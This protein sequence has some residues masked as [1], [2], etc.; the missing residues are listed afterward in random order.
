MKQLKETYVST[1]L[2]LVRR[3]W[4]KQDDQDLS[5]AD[6]YSHRLLIFLRPDLDLDAKK[7]LKDSS[8]TQKYQCETIHTWFLASSISEEGEENSQNHTVILNE[9]H[10]CLGEVNERQRR[11]YL[12]YCFPLGTHKW[13]EI[14]HALWHCCFTKQT[15]PIWCCKQ[16]KTNRIYCKHF[17]NY[18]WS[19]LKSFQ[20]RKF[21]ADFSVFAEKI[22]FL[23][24]TVSIKWSLVTLLY[25]L[26]TAW[27]TWPILWLCAYCNCPVYPQDMI[28]GAL[29]DLCPELVEITTTWLWRSFS[30]SVSLA[31][32]APHSTP[33]PVSYERL[34]Y[35]QI[36]RL[37]RGDMSHC[38]ELQ[39]SNKGWA[40][41]QKEVILALLIRWWKV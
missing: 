35:R 20:H 38:R 33:L 5:L 22:C 6:D 4:G 39:Y 34:L 14:V 37:W 24:N 3:V 32:N 8:V 18:V 41:W 27:S 26:S 7:T 2:F 10:L 15:L 21:T 9:S 23:T 29:S 1:S 19:G 40:I 11:S 16:V 17:L 31:Q 28:N 12:G 30:S 36:V 25:I 13:V